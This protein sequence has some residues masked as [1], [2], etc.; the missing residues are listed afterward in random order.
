MRQCIEDA[1]IAMH[2]ALETLA[3]RCPEWLREVALQHWYEVYAPGAAITVPADPAKQQAMAQALGR[4]IA[5][6]LSAVDADAPALLQVPALR[7]LVE[8]WEDCFQAGESLADGD[9]DCEEVPMP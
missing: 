6:L 3:A 1:N 4:D 7:V 2:V 5:A 8:L 9:K